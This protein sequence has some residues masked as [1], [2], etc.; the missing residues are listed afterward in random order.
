MAKPM[1]GQGIN[2]SSLDFKPLEAHWFLPAKRNMLNRNWIYEILCA[3]IVGPRYFP[4]P[5]LE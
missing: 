3:P 1:G 5:W 4:H 2:R